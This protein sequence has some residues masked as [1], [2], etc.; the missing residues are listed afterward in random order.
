M[1][2]DKKERLNITYV[3]VSEDIRRTFERF[4]DCPIGYQ[5][6][7]TFFS[8]VYPC[9]RLLHLHSPYGEP[10]IDV[11]MITDILFLMSFIFVRDPLTFKLRDSLKSQPNPQWA[12]EKCEAAKANKCSHPIYF[13]EPRHR[14][15]KTTDSVRIKLQTSATAD[16]T[17]KRIKKR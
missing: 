7:V 6:F 8:F 2:K 14:T 13:N 17:T 16:K 9:H 1:T 4:H 12:A 5:C 11:T 3:K 15:C 10:T